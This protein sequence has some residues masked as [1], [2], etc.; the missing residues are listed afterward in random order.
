M[1]LFPRLHSS[2]HTTAD[3]SFFLRC[4]L[5]WVARGQNNLVD[6]TPG[7]PG[8]WDPGP[9]T[10]DPGPGT[11]D[12]GPGTWD[13]GSGTQDPGLG[14][15][16]RDLGPQTRDPGPP[17]RES[18]DHPLTLIGKCRVLHTKVSARVPRPWIGFWK[19][20]ELLSPGRSKA[21]WALQSTENTT[22]T[23]V[24][25]SEPCSVSFLCAHV[26]CSER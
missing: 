20:L 9:G 22:N 7:P 23:N 15:W 2:T 25:R 8:T 6:L 19:R 26:P 3:T 17:R 4:S 18:N 10:R 5:L 16:T 11:R 1:E 21:P 13:L 24:Y 14:T 12:L